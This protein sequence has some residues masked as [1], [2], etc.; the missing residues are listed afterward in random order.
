MSVLSIPNVVRRMHAHL[1]LLLLLTLLV[2]GGMYLG[3]PLQVKLDDIQAFHASLINLV[4]EGDLLIGNLRYP[5]GYALVMAP[6]AAIA[7]HLGAFEE[8]FILLVQVTLCA[9]IPFLLYDTVRRHHSRRV[10]LIVAL[11]A[12]LDVFGLQWAH[13]YYPVWMVAFCIVLAIWIMNRS[14]HFSGASLATGFCAAGGV[15]GIATLCRFNLAPV[16]LV[17]GALLLLVKAIPFRQRFLAFASLGTGCLTVLLGYLIAIHIPSTGTLRVNCIGGPNLILSVKGGGIPVVAENGAATARLLRLVS[18]PAIEP[19]DWTQRVHPLWQIPGPWVEEEASRAFL[20]QEPAAEI[21][22]ELDVW[23]PGALVYHIGPCATDSL[24][25]HVALE[26]I[27]SHPVQ[28]LASL[29]GEILHLLLQRQQSNWH[30]PHI[31]VL[32]LED[33]LSPAFP[34]K[35]AWSESGSF[36][37]GE[38]RGERLWPLPVR[39]YSLSRDLLHALK[40]LAIPALIWGLL[41]RRPL[42]AGAAWALLCWLTM[43]AVIIAAVPEERLIAPLWP[44]WPLLIGG[45]LADLW[46][47]LSALPGARRESARPS[48]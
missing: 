45:M 13:L 17:T 18:L 27:M 40:L 32:R 47:R 30:L 1:R 39:L 25:T 6:A 36:F 38:Y 11:A 20:A 26:A 9:C 14:L 15:L 3:Y 7:R 23:F 24:L 29:P 8:R 28:F 46:Q 43:M 19:M 37:G 48:R 35:R 42:F 22:D 2:R 21:P 41:S 44:L 31:D 5:T 10:A 33:T 12:L 4:V 34:L 16:V